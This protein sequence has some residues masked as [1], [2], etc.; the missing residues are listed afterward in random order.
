[1]KNVNWKELIVTHVEKVVLGMAGLIVLIGLAT[2]SW[3]TYE[4]RPSQFEEKLTTGKNNF[5][6]GVWPTDSEKEFQADDPGLQVVRLF[7]GAR[8]YPYSTRWVLPLN[9]RKEKIKEPFWQRF[10]MV[11]ADP[12]KMLMELLPWAGATTIA[13]SESGEIKVKVPGGI[14]GSQVEPPRV[15]GPRVEGPRQTGAVGSTSASSDGSADPQ[16]SG[17]GAAPGNGEGYDEDLLSS[18]TGAGMSSTVKKEKRG[19]G[20]GTR[21]VAIRAVFPLKKQVEQLKTA[22]NLDS[23]VE[24]AQQ[25]VFWDFELE[26][27]TA[28]AGANPWSGPWEKVDIAYALD[29]L[30]RTD[31]DVD[32][33]GERFRDAVFTMPLPYRVSGNW[34][35]PQ[36]SRLVSHPRIKQV[37]TTE[38]QLEQE[39]R[40]TALIEAAKTQKEAVK[41]PG[42]FGPIQ[43]DTKGLAR[44]ATQNS[45][46]RDSYMEQ[47]KEYGSSG[48]PGADSVANVNPYGGSGYQSQGAFGLAKVT[49]ISEVLLFRF[50]D[51]SVV[52]GNAYRYKIKLKIENPNFGREAS[53]LENIASREGEYRNTEWSEP[54]TP[55]IVKD[56]TD[57]YI[58]KLD[59]RR[60]VAEIE[61]HEWRTDT[62]SYVNGT[63]KGLLAG[64]QIATWR[65]E[66]TRRGGYKKGTGIETPV[67]RP[68]EE[69]YDDEVID[70]VTPNTLIDLGKTVLLDPA[71]HPELELAPK[72]VNLSLDEIVMINRFGELVQVDSVAQDAAYKSAAMLIAEQE[73]LWAVYRNKSAAQPQM[74]G[75]DSLMGG[76]AY[77]EGPAY[78]GGSGEEAGAAK[79]GGRRKSSLKRSPQSIMQQMNGD[80]GF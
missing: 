17:Y 21:F 60:E 27:Q 74:S 56:E 16:E 72:R 46:M 40:N 57:F 50:L 75:L 32:V 2:T 13:T 9:K 25:L 1:M 43:H 73:R 42:G 23:S 52:P 4:K 12:G 19:E 22:L 51:F 10:E 26:R 76:S 7:D 39:R 34:G 30:A 20:R 11:V 37:L 58:A 29:L 36:N 5:E 63:F 65:E 31:F 61:V 49:E 28:V 70:F 38:Q 48:E 80:E 77:G 67:L 66:D 33:V 47:M 78:P 69:T 54:S 53:E 55:A 18:T 79:K 59:A 35:S 45:A 71:D 8:T 64:D 15:E 44:Q 68:Y 6:S 62:G 14:P 41:T 3:G 24:A